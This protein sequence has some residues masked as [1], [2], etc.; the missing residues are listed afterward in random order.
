MFEQAVVLDE[1]KVS[2][3][4]CTY[5]G[6]RFLAEQLDSIL[7]QSYQNI[8]VVIVDDCSNDQT[9][10][11]LH[12]Y[13][14]QDNRVRVFQNQ[15][16]LGFVKN[17]EK[18]IATCQSDYIALADQDDV[19]FK[20]KIA[21]LMAEIGESLLIYSRVSLVDEN[22][23]SLKEEFPGPSIKR[24]DGSCALSL[25]IANCVTGHACLIRRE[26]FEQARPAL[27]NM[28]YHDQ[29]LA[30]VAA[31]AGRMKASGSVLSYYR[32]HGKNVVFKGK[33]RKK[34]GERK[35]VKA[36]RKLDAHL[37]FVSA[38]LCA[39]VLTGTE[40]SVLREY[41]KLSSRSKKLFFNNA[42]KVFLIEH[43]ELFLA[44]SSNI[45]KLVRKMC[46]GRWFFVFFPFT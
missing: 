23:N 17:F 21:V 32:S 39:R 29:W 43:Q 30:I 6:E 22:G 2:I 46:R 26:L 11:I 9:L 10:S 15:Q 18:A 3:A 1:K 33:V 37:N 40:E 14:E 5:N 20:D 19:W 12:R 35:H 8:E 25:I 31:A 7:N 38:V 13:A 44:S 41:L 27:A 42:L 34:R 16:N 36:M 28:P 4:M 45:E 24:I